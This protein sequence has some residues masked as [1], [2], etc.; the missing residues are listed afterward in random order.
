VSGIVG[1]LT[2]ESQ[3]VS[4]TSSVVSCA[5]T[6]SPAVSVSN[7]V[8]HDEFPCQNRNSALKNHHISC[9]IRQLEFNCLWQRSLHG[10]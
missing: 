4:S 3:Q 6:P 5:K 9:V 10:F 7:Q 2:G 8:Y 1:R